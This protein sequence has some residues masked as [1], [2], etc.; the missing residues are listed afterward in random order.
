MSLKTESFEQDS[1]SQLNGLIPQ[2]EA[3]SNTLYN[4]YINQ[5][6]LKLVLDKHTHSIEEY[7]GDLFT[8]LGIESANLLN[9]V[10][11]DA[12]EYN[13]TTESAKKRVEEIEVQQK[14]VE[15]AMS[16]LSD[17]QKAIDE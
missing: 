15:Q 4:T 8:G 9:R 5:I 10:P 11:F 14:A 7:L 1:H 2:I 6:I 17:F 16:I 12:I 13:Q 3:W